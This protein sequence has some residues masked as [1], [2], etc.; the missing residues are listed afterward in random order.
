MSESAFLVRVPEAESLVGELRR[1]FDPSAALGVPVHITVLYPFMSSMLIDEGVLASAKRIV[2]AMKEFHFELNAIGRF[3][4]ASY[5]S[6]DPIESFVSLTQALVREFPN[7]PPYGGRFSTI[8]PHL[9]VADKSAANAAIAEQ[10]L[11]VR[12]KNQPVQCE[13]QHL[14]LWEN[15]T[16]KWRFFHRFALKPR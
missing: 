8:V 13:C 4:D 10:E 5:L 7:Y 3:P 12:I 11:K 9:T 14:E 15:S 16:G 1:R 6:P 2:S